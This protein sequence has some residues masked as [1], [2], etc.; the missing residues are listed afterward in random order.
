MSKVQ[1]KSNAPN[2]PAM[3]KY[4][5]NAGSMRSRDELKSSFALTSAASSLWLHSHYAKKDFSEN[6]LTKVTKAKFASKSNLVRQC[7][8]CQVLYTNFHQCK[9]EGK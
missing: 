9:S 2:W 8:E 7:M 3:V 4:N 6:I 1:V 5:E